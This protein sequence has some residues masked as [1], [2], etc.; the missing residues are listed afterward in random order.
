MPDIAI[1]TTVLTAILGVLSSIG[2]SIITKFVYDIAQKDKI[3][4]GQTEI[5]LTDNPDETLRRIAE[6]LAEVQEHPRVFLSFTSADKEFANQLN[7][8]LRSHGIETWTTDEQIRVGDSLTDKIKEGISTS[9]W[10]IFIVSPS[11]MKSK[12]LSRELELAL[13]NE[14]VRERPFILPVVYQG[15]ELPLQLEDRVFADFRQDY[16]SGLRS[17]LARLKPASTHIILSKP[18]AVYAL[19]IGIG[20]YMHPLPSIANA[21]KNIMAIRDLLTSPTYGNLSIEKAILLIDEQATRESLI[22]A[23][24]QLTDSAK[25]NDIILIYFV[26]HG[27]QSVGGFRGSESYLL[28]Y[29][30]QLEHLD[31]TAISGTELTQLLSHSHARKTL[32]ALDNGGVSVSP[33]VVSGEKM[34]LYFQELFK[35]Y[36]DIVVTSPNELAYHLR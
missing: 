7:S 12:F 10:V 31:Q 17:L 32:I 23:I 2:V 15:N 24:N 28:P 30:A 35:S 19:L 1:L 8:E 34:N 27:V 25:E 14:K 21:V 4:V 33:P 18:S 9:Q 5:T 6:K 3:K 36:N 29:D 26:G 16:E 13:Q 20:R 11:S 22:Q